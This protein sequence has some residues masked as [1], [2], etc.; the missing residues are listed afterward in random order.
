MLAKDDPFVGRFGAEIDGEP[1]E[2][3]IFSDRPG[4]YDGELRAEGKRLPFVGRRFGDGLVGQIGFPDD[5][6]AIRARVL[7]A[8][9]LLERQSATPWRFY[10]LTDC[11]ATKK[12]WPGR[13]T[14]YCRQIEA[15]LNFP[16]ADNSPMNRRAHPSTACDAAVPWYRS[17]ARCSRDCGRS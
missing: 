1:H 13:A 14:P 9:L 5:A 10:R 7:G 11:T 4:N 12:A 17:S 8:V 3:L 2:L 6:I 16:F 15:L